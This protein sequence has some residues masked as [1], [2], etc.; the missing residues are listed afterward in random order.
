VPVP[1]PPEDVVYGIGRI[2]A[3]GRIADRA[4]ASAK[5]RERHGQIH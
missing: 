3:S 4:V 1:S 5:T 2:D